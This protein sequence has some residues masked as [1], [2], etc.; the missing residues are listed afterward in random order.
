MTAGQVPET[1]MTDDTAD[2]SHIAEFAWFDWVMFWDK[3][4]GYPNNKIRG[5]SESS[6]ANFSLS[7]NPV[8]K[9]SSPELQNLG[10]DLVRP[11]TP[12]I[13]PLKFLIRPP[14]PPQR[15]AIIA[16]LAKPWGNFQISH[17]GI[18]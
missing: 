13:S 8:G 3:V 15:I 7:K 14:P 11:R 1:L 5:S 16:K 12:K 2:I 4:P 6:P 9:M 10:G 18:G 17:N